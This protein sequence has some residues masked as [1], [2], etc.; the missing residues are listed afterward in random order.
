MPRGGEVSMARRSGWQPMTAVA[1]CAESGYE[2]RILNF[3]MSLAIVST[4]CIEA[5]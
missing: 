3:D 1:A 2:P 5:C 4:T